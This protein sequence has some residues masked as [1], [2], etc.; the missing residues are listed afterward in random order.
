MK[1]TRIIIIILFFLS[2]CAPVY[3]QHGYQVE[4]ILLKE[5]PKIGID[6][7]KDIFDSYGTPSIKIEDVDNTWLY[8]VSQK[9]KNVFSKDVFKEQLIFAF[10]FDKDNVLLS[11][12]IYDQSNMREINKNSNKTSNEKSNYTI[13]DQISDAFTRGL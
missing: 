11:S 8:I 9:K 2:N 5:S 3:K 7:K 6:S 4:D 12:S 13:L 10:K 1:I